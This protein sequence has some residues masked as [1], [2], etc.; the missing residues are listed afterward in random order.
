MSEKYFNFV[1]VSK[2]F[3]IN[4]SFA[5]FTSLVESMVLLV[6]AHWEYYPNYSFLP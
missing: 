4:Q 6:K 2:N 5:I 1:F 3:L